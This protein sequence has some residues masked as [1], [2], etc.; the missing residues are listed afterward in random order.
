MKKHKMDI[1][2]LSETKRKGKETSKFEDY[3]LIYSEKAKQERA[4]SGVAIL[5]HKKYTRNVEDI[6][7]ISDRIVKV[8]LELNQIKLHLISTYV[9]DISKPI[10]E[11]EN[12]HQELQNIIDKYHC[13]INNK[14]KIVIFV[15]LNAR[16]RQQNNTRRVA[17]I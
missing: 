16:L 6:E 2:G 13:K 10:E 5:H 12:F 8:S 15:D 11:S 9:P 17:K 4:H 1:C 3:T 7:Y 14:N